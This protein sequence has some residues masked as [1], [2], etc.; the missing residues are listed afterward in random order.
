M[1]SNSFLIIYQFF[2]TNVEGL[3]NIV[4]THQTVTSLSNIIK[5]K[6]YSI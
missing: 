1:R 4:G 3:L 6:Y 2:E 5:L